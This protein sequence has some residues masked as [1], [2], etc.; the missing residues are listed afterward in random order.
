MGRKKRTGNN[1]REENFIRIELELKYIT[2][3][4][5]SYIE[6][7]KI[8]IHGQIKPQSAELVLQ[9]WNN[10]VMLLPTLVA[11]IV[12]VLSAVVVAIVVGVAVVE[13]SRLSTIGL[14]LRVAQ[15]GA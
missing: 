8:K 11:T 14:E 4:T 6:E 15:A 5:L 7:L 2:Q 10:S 9:Y 12:V 1:G 13:P 3:L